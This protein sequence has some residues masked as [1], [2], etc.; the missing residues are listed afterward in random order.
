MDYNVENL[1]I[2]ALC[3]DVAEL[4]EMINARTI[5]IDGIHP[6]LLYTALHAAAEFGQLDSVRVL[7][8]QGSANVNAR[9]ARL[10]RTPLFYA[11]MHRRGDIVRLLLSKGANPR[12]RDV[13]GQRAYQLIEV[14]SE[15]DDRLRDSLLDPPGRVPCVIL[16]VS[17]PTCLAIEWDGN[18]FDKNCAKIDYYVVR[19]R[20]KPRLH[21]A[22]MPSAEI[23]E[24]KTLNFSSADKDGRFDPEGRPEE[25]WSCDHSASKAYEITKLLPAT[26]YVIQITAHSQVGFGPPS[27]LNCFRT[28]ETVPEPPASAPLLVRS[29]PYMLS[30][31]V[32]PPLRDNGFPVDGYVI[33]YR[34]YATVGTG[35]LE[36][37]VGNTKWHTFISD[38]PSNEFSVPS[39][40]P[41]AK[42]VFKARAKNLAGLG[43]FSVESAPLLTGHAVQAVSK[44]S[45][46]VIIAWVSH[47]LRQA[48]LFDV[49]IRSLQDEGDLR[50]PFMP[51]TTGLTEQYFEIKGLQPASYYQFRIRTTYE[52]VEE[53][54]EEGM[55]SGEIRTD[56]DRPDPP[57][58][59]VLV[60]GS[61]MQ[62][63]A[64]FEWE[65]TRI[66]GQPI[67]D[68]ELSA[69]YKLH[70][71]FVIGTTSTKRLCATELPINHRLFFRVRARNLIG[72]S[73]Y[74][75]VSHCLEIVV[76]PPP[77]TPVVV[78][79]GQTWVEV[80]FEPPADFT[81]ERY[82]LRM[83]R[84]FKEGR[85]IP[86]SLQAAVIG[87][88][89]DAVDGHGWTTLPLEIVTT[90]VRIR[91]LMPLS[92]LCF[93]VR[94]LTVL[95]W[96]RW[97]GISDSVTTLRR[98]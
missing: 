12:L 63:S 50:A 7:I 24:N 68:Y 58:E 82:Q 52:E 33:L 75:G 49:Q 51:L 41:S 90:S 89:A 56:D 31:C 64:T 86:A 13:E 30:L 84:L 46:S 66:N 67:I 8:E 87:N 91:D 61:L 34:L 48:I 76:V 22:V 78:E 73:D 15:E 98:M 2:A 53:E 79:R 29:S 39:L 18:M 5:R 70:H 74:S 23:M 96:S 4:I 1:V 71:W 32:R 45:T 47:P 21:E 97:S 3:G 6:A 93:Q 54:W 37:K 9:C 80:T 19:W 27:R 83:R 92:T 95:G 10:D 11:A 69:S 28:R 59:P 72:W 26:D 62:T 88:E 43:N 14:T 42:Y 16:R 40:Y 44:T 38:S 60:P 17:M 85:P 77:E 36:T 25:G 35:G 65:S 20:V 57:T 81:V 55:L 94:A